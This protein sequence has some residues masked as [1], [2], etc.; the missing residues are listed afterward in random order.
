MMLFTTGRGTPYGS[1][2]QTL[3]ISTNSTLA[4]FKSDWIDFD[5]GRLLVEMTGEE[6][7]DGFVKFIIEIAN[8]RKARNEKK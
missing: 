1:F 7:L 3:K 4:H 8:G 2:I 6:L 5:E